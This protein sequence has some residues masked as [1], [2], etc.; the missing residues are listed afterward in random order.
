MGGF[1]MISSRNGILILAL[2]IASGC[3]QKTGSIKEDE[4]LSSK[5]VEQAEASLEQISSKKYPKEVR[6]NFISS[7]VSTGGNYDTCNCVLEI[8]EDNLSIAEFSEAEI[9]MATGQP[10]DKLMKVLG[11]SRLTCM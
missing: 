11:E 4:S 7:C 8:V 1:K 6:N 5:I 9:R 2:F 3:D 10:N